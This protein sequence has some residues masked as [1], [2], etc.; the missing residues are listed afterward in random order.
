[1][2]TVYLLSDDLLWSS[3][4]GAVVREQGAELITARDLDDLLIL[5]KHHRPDG[6][7]LDLGAVGPEITRVVQ[8]LREIC[9]PG[10]RI[11]AYG[12]H[13]D[14]AG[15]KAAREA[16]C[17][18]VLPRSQFAEHMDS[19]LRTWLSAAAGAGPTLGRSADKV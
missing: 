15:L 11:A 19:V 10:L 18:P 17:D 4:I 12:P 1:M 8:Q 9:T 6:V 13:V 14:V 16:G 5:C 3:R 7:I 2:A